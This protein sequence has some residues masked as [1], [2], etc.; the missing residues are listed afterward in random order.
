MS[1]LLY[2]VPVGVVF[3]GV[4]FVGGVFVGVV[5]VGVVSATLLSPIASARLNRPPATIA[6]VFAPTAIA[7][8]NLPLAEQDALPDFIVPN[9]EDTQASNA[10]AGAGATPVASAETATAPNTPPAHHRPTVLAITILN[11]AG[12]TDIAGRGSGLKA[13]PDV[14]KESSGNHN[15][16]G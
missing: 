11:V 10:R 5:F 6:E 4:V 14:G 3:V 2:P 7:S 16:N 15:G 13:A 8:D 1:K 9:A 12:I